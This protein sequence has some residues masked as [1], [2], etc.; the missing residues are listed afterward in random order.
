M[1]LE[2]RV[3]NGLKE[4]LHQERGRCHQVFHALQ[5]IDRPFLLRNE[6]QDCFASL[7]DSEETKTL[8]AT[9]LAKVISQTQE[10][11]VR[12]PWLCFAVRPQ[13]GKWHFIKFHLETMTVSLVSASEFLQ[14]KEQ[15][16]DGGS[17]GENWMLEFDIGPFTRDV[18]K[19]REARSIG[20][21]VEFLNRRLSSQLFQGNGHGDR[22]LFEFLRVHSCQGQQLMLLDTVEDP[23]SLRQALRDAE[24][25]L[26]KQDPQ[27]KWKEHA[28]ALD[29][30]GFAAGWG[31]TAGRIRDTMGLLLDLLEAP[32]PKAMEE[33]LARIPMVFSIAILSPHGWFGQ[34][35]V[36]GRPDTGGQVVYILDQV[37]ALEREMRRNLLDEG[38]EIDPQIVVVTRLI[39]EADET[40]CNERLEPIAGTEHAR[41]LRVPFR[42]SSGEVVPQW[43]SRFEIWPY[44]E[45]F[46]LEVE[47]ELLSELGARPDLIIGNYSDGNLVASLLAPRLG[48]TQCTIAHALEKAK[49]LYSD[50][51]WKENDA[52]YH[53]ASQFTADLISMNSSDFIITSTYQ[54]IAGTEQTVG[55]Y[56]AHEAFT[57]PGLFRT[58]QGIDVHDPKFNIVSPGADEE[59]YFPADKKEKRLLHL[60]PEIEELVFG[61]QANGKAR[62]VLANREK[63]LLFSMAR[64]DK[65]KNLTGLVEWYGRNP[66]LRSAANLFIVGGYVEPER[67]GDQE[68]REQ[69][70]QMIRLLEEHDLH[71]QVRWVEAQVDRER[72]GELYRFVADS[73]G[74][75]VQPALFEAFGL[76]VIESMSTGL[77]TFATCFGGPQEIIEDGVSGFHIDPT[78]GDEAAARMVAFF[79][80]CQSRPEYWDEISRGALE[81]VEA[82]YTW[83]LY[84]ERLMTLTRVYGFWK[85]VTRLDR[86]AARRYL[87]MFYTLQFRPLAE[88]IATAK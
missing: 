15:Q 42:E 31:A 39:P 30:L 26:G 44:L 21:G 83:K 59:I 79:D 53:F 65:I 84:A 43:I 11:V 63:P 1:R 71:D 72:N 41:I 77:P 80:T 17:D 32:S 55:Q 37:R 51:Y 76:T 23:D 9:P 20:R 70:E 66:A 33:F 69:I 52:Q 38:L 81:R 48:V 10:A 2:K 87:E 60:I 57:M 73:R 3:L 78:H 28:T 54:E 40:T 49:Y 6:I 24:S 7:C 82:R 45:R 86:A 56:E 4:Y 35:N 58:V 19:L 13:V 68:E 36:L 8:E 34:A 67:S 74:A 47:K 12:P 14:L 64:M 22:L 46:T 29:K 88:A 16:L 85:Y 62:G 18:P 50:L 5:K 25:Y 61:D 75:F 27:S